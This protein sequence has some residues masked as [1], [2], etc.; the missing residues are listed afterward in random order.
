MIRHKLPRL[1]LILIT[2]ATIGLT[3][4]FVVAQTA[5]LSGRVTDAETGEALTGANVVVASP[6]LT[7]LKGAATSVNG[8]Y[9]ISDL[10]VGLYDLTVTYFGY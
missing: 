8:N 10:P 6:S 1:T 3:P 2:V 5:T 9:S 4:V 7:E